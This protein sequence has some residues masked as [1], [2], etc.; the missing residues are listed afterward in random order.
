MTRLYDH[1]LRIDRK[2]VLDLMLI[3]CKCKTSISKLNSI[4]IPILCYFFFFQRQRN[5]SLISKS[6]PLY[7]YFFPTKWLTM[8]YWC[9]IL[10]WFPLQ[11]GNN[12]GWGRIPKDVDIFGFKHHGNF[13][14]GTAESFKASERG[15]WSRW[16]RNIPIWIYNH[17]RSLDKAKTNLI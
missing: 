5:F 9:L 2:K 16:K 10:L 1:N 12:K 14:G 8:T 4:F 3:G 7:Y 17:E 13:P 11:M 6:N 15:S